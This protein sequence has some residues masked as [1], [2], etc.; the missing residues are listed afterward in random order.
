MH[1]IEPRESLFPDFLKKWSDVSSNKPCMTRR[2][3]GAFDI[4]LLKLYAK[5]VYPRERID[6]VFKA[7]IHHPYGRH[8][9]LK[10]SSHPLEFCF[11]RLTLSISQ[12][13][14]KASV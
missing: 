8:F 1:D 7:V 10:N 3:P 12:I 11:T 4:L 2:Y 9:V 5:C 6:C 14:S 13:P